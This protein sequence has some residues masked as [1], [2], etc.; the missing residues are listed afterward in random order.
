MA[1]GI[2]KGSV[3]DPDYQRECWLEMCRHV[4]YMLA[5]ALL[6]GGCAGVEKNKV[7][8]GFYARVVALMHTHTH[9]TQSR[10]C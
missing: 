8:V 5:K 1:S 7:E 10:T 4:K 6:F 3:M 9:E 2:R